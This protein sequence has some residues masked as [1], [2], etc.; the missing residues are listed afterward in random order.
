MKEPTCDFCGAPDPDW[1]MESCGRG[2]PE[3]GCGAEYAVCDEC[4]DLGSAGRASSAWMQDHVCG[5]T[6]ANRKYRSG[7]AGILAGTVV[8]LT[9][10]FAGFLVRHYGLDGLLV[11]LLLMHAGQVAL[12]LGFGLALLHRVERLEGRTR[13]VRR[14]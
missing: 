6:P 8:V 12:V 1:T 13:G 9:G 14:G 10:G 3:A 7:L 4:R 5:L 2:D 11:A